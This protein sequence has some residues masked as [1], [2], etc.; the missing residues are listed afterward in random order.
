LA[1]GDGGNDISMIQEAHVGIG[2]FGK[3][4][5]QAAYCS[6]YAICDFKA[7]RRLMFWH[8]RGFALRFT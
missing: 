1:I 3:E 7:L 8:G 2:L 4:G 5:N 6:D